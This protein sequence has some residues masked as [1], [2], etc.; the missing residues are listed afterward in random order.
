MAGSDAPKKD[1]HKGKHRERDKH[2]HKKD[3]DRHKGHGSRREKRK[4]YDDSSEEE[5]AT[6]D[7]PPVLPSV[8]KGIAVTVDDF[9]KR[10]TE[11]RAW[12]SEQKGIYLDEV[13]TDAARKL[14]VI[15]GNE[16]NAGRLPAALYNGLSETKVQ[17]AERTRHKWAFAGKMT[18]AEKLQ[19]ESM[20]DTVDT[21]THRDHA[22]VERR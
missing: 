19:L 17:A 16:W 9:Y 12:L 3:K 5:V 20:K 10:S 2:K 6:I 4:R 1:K 18:D 13:P 14:F 15:F 22:N 8:C 11:F 7:V 21:L